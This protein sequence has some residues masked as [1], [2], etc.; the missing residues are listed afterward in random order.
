MHPIGIERDTSTP[1]ACASRATARRSPHP[2]PEDASPVITSPAPIRFGMGRTPGPHVP[3]PGD[4]PSA[5]PG[6][7]RTAA[8]RA[9]TPRRPVPPPAVRAHPQPSHPRPAA[10][11][12]A[13]ARV[14]PTSARNHPDAG[15]LS[16]SSS[17]PFRTH[18]RPC[19]RR[20]PAASSPR[21][22]SPLTGHSSG[23]I[24]SLPPTSIETAGSLAQ[25]A[26]ALP[27]NT[28]QV[29]GGKRLSPAARGRGT[30]PLKVSRGG[31]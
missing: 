18:S 11:P 30:P 16:R 12:F 8:P 26:V 5:G 2:W 21:R 27:A 20:D 10:T 19:Q 23:S 28:D 29:I 13:V 3:R 7:A 4:L 1:A 25:D 14:S 17:C 6:P 9:G 31:Y 24:L 22:P 15:R